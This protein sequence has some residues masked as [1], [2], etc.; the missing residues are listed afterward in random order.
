V[1]LSVELCSLTI[2]RDDHSVANLIAC[3]LFGDGAAAVVAVI[4]NLMIGALKLPPAGT[5]STVQLISWFPVLFITFLASIYVL[6]KVP[7]L[8]SH[9]FSG[10]AGG[11]SAALVEGPA[12][13]GAAAL[14]REL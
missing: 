14:A 1:L 5:L 7:S 8:T 2:Q 12:A 4:G 6:L 3:G 10:A 11:S 9:I 13:A